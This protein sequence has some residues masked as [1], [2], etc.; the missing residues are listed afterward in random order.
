L[1]PSTILRMIDRE[2]M[3]AIEE[4]TWPGSARWVW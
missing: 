3:F 4:C 1:S 2:P